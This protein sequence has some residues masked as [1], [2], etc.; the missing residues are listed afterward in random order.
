[1]K[2]TLFARILHA[3]CAAAVLTFA[4]AALAQE[5]GCP[6]GLSRLQQRLIDKAGQGPEEVRRFLYIRRAILQLDTGDTLEWVEAVRTANPACVKGA[7]LATGVP[8]TDL[9][10]ADPGA[11]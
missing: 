6:A 4:G 9:A 5:A 2:R 8:T 7:R 11:H 1:M 10:L 3:A